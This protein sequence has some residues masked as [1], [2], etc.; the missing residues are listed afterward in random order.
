MNCFIFLA[1]GCVAM[2]VGFL[3]VINSDKSKSEAP[4][5][6][7]PIKIGGGLLLMMG[8]LLF[9]GSLVGMPWGCM[10]QEIL[11]TTA[12]SLSQPSLCSVVR[13]F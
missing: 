13:L 3:L 10:P 2:A 11:P 4:S 1:G 5:T 7:S 6:N 12:S 9:I 8:I